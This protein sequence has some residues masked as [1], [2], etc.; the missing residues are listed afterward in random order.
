MAALG[1]RA[2]FPC[3]ACYLWYVLPPGRSFILAWI[4]LVTACAADVAPP[5]KVV[6]AKL[7]PR[8]EAPAEPARGPAVTPEAQ[9]AGSLL[10]QEEVG[11]EFQRVEERRGWRGAD[12]VEAEGERAVQVRWVG[13]SAKSSVHRI[14]EAR[15]VFPSEGRAKQ[16]FA[17][18]VAKEYDGREVPAV[19]GAP[20][21]GDDSRAYADIQGTAGPLQDAY[22]FVFRRGRVVAC[23]RPLRSVEIEPDR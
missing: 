13:P 5:P 23:Y 12:F 20:T 21:I 10:A 8:V 2:L 9:L 6:E 18:H 19:S 14:T 1:I 4:P 17:A 3:K 7:P 15:W 11:A 22:T 16:F